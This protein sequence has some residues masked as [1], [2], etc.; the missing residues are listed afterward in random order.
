MEIQLWKLSKEVIKSSLIMCI[1]TW[2][3]F[4][5]YNRI[6]EDDLGM[7][8]CEMNCT[9]NIKADLLKNAAAL[10]Y[11]YFI[12]SPKTKNDEKKCYECLHGYHG[13]VNRCFKVSSN[14]NKGIT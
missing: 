10:P 4:F 5:P 12:V 7:G 8:M 3:I 11:K 9:L 2:Y 14:F 13:I 1:R 6:L